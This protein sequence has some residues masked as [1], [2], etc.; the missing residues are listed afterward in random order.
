V[1][2]CVTVTALL[3]LWAYHLVLDP[4]RLDIGTAIQAVFVL[5]FF[6]YL[7]LAF[8]GIAGVSR[9]FRGPP[10]VSKYV[11]FTDGLA[12]GVEILPESL[13]F[14]RHGLLAPLARRVFR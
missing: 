4:E 1:I 9:Q 6:Y 2:S 13:H 10:F 12:A 7:P 14:A 5:A 11:S 8:W 3:T